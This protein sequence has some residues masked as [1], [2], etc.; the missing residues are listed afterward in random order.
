MAVVDST[1]VLRNAVDAVLASGNRCLVVSGWASPPADLPS[2]RVHVIPSAPHEWLFPRCRAVVCHGGAGT[3]A[4]VVHAGIPCVVVPILRFFD[5]AGWGA[6][7]E[8][9]GIGVCVRGTPSSDAI[10]AALEH[11]LTDTVVAQ[12]KEVGAE[13]QGESGLVR[14]VEQL[15]WCLCARLRGAPGIS[16]AVVEMCRKNCLA[17]RGW[18]LREAASS[19]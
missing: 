17:C 2:D 11:V 9:K 1:D 8:N 12:A 4:R 19:G 16:D 15:E 10:Q 5:Q 3:F 18:Q 13:V 6:T 14:A 7:A